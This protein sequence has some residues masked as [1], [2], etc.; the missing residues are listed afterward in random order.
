MRFLTA[1]LKKQLNKRF[2][3]ILLVA[4][5]VNLLLFWHGQSANSADRWAHEERQQLQQALLA[6]EEDQRFSY[7]RKQCAMLD[8]CYGWETYKR[9]LSSGVPTP[10]ITTEMLLYQQIYE[11]GSYLRYTGSLYEERALFSGIYQELQRISNYRQNILQTIEDTEKRLELSIFSQ[12]GTFAYRNQIEMIRQLSSLTEIKPVYDISDGVLCFQT[13]PVT[14]LLALMLI[15]YL[16]V[17]M[18]VAE[19]QKGM[20]CILR[21]TQNGRLPLTAAKLVSAFLLTLSVTA[22]LWGCNFAFCGIR[23]G[24]GDL[25][26]PVQSLTGYSTCPLRITVGEY[27]ALFFLL[28]WLG[29]GVVGLLCMVLGRISRRI[30][31]SWVGM[32][33][34][35]AA[36]YAL[37]Q[38]I[39]AISSQVHLKYINLFYLLTPQDY[40]QMCRN[41]NLFGYPVALAEVCPVLLVILLAVG[42]IWLL[43]LFCRKKSEDPTIRIRRLR[44]PGWLP[45]PGSSTALVGHELWKLLIECGSLLVLALFILLNVQEPKPLALNTE[46]LTYR[47]Y[48]ELMAGP[49]T[50]QHLALLEREQERFDQLR[51]QRERLQQDLE[52]GLITE[53]ELQMLCQPLDR[54]LEAEKILMD[55]VYPRIEQ[56][57]RLSAGGKE[58]WMVYEQGYEYLFG[59]DPAHDKSVSAALTVAG[60]ILCFANFYPMETAM[61]M[62]PLLNVYARGRNATAKS[63][64]LV[65]FLVAA[66][67]FLVAQIPDYWYVAKNYGFPLLNAPICSLIGFS[68]WSDRIPIWGGIIIF[69]LC[70][71][72]TVLSVTAMVMLVCQWTRSQLLSV[73]AATGAFLAPLLLHLLEVKALD[74]VSLFRPMTG[75]WLLAARDPL[76]LSLLYYG[77]VFALGAFSV[78]QLVRASRRGLRSGRLWER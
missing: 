77:T 61:G 35:L 22:V 25:S 65:A 41:L 39:S 2:L 63:K 19:Q 76:P 36:E 32:G 49:V 16:C 70:R 12:P 34:L 71:L 69:E 45:R 57:I 50:R 54:A 73:C 42:V 47:N 17:E 14:D 23:F 5:L 46:Q 28:K 72:M 64:L 68:G 75:G 1:E 13:S 78:W 37:T 60:I 56:I 53:S 29:Y 21:A 30:M 18:T 26:R 24:F 51:A 58:V 74:P 9:E 67:L 44:W 20:L 3:G 6:M 38:N 4:F 7:V 27:L 62:Q 8:A 43:F 11:N 55:K 15:L 33:A 10:Q 59:L 40:L 31:T 52:A 66:V 48:M